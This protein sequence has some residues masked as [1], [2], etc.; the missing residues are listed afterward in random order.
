MT[1]TT[2]RPKVLIRLTA[3][4]KP[5]CEIAHGLGDGDKNPPLYDA[6]DFPGNR[7]RDDLEAALKAK[8]PGI[9]VGV[10]ET[11][12]GTMAGMRSV[13]RQVNRDEF[14][15]H[16]RIQLGYA[17]ANRF[18]NINDPFRR[19][20]RVRLFGKDKVPIW[21]GWF[22]YPLL[23]E[24]SR[25]QMKESGE[26][27]AKLFERS[28][29]SE[30]DVIEEAYYEQVMRERLAIFERRREWWRVI[31]WGLTTALGVILAY[32]ALAPT[33]NGM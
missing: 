4:G 20:V 11:E 3:H 31:R 16:W 28:R 21:S 2:D 14:M 23:I 33:C 22:H 18:G 1:N 10:G 5:Y 30:R 26:R 32:G 25:S 17:K 24:D 27:L 15:D 6:L 13:N 7:G 8:Y 12:R 19:V 9:K 29:V